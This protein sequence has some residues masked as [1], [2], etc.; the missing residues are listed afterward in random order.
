MADLE[1]R[2]EGE[3]IGKMKLLGREIKVSMMLCFGDFLV[4]SDLR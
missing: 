4:Y 2:R 3:R 1:N